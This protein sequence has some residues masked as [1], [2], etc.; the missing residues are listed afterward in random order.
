MAVTGVVGIGVSSLWS[1]SVET[2]LAQLR[3]REQ[4]IVRAIRSMSGSAS[5]DGAGTATGADAQRAQLQA[6]LVQVQTQIAQAETRQAE[7]RR[8]GATSTSASGG[9]DEGGEPHAAGEDEATE[10]GQPPGYRPGSLDVEA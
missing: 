8:S 4:E 5:G 6:Q 9:A 10:A 7:S 3:R 1:S 2:L